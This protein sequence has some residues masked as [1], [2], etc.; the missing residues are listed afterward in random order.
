M[1][2]ADSSQL[3]FRHLY[4]FYLTVKLG[5]LSLAAKELRL[6]VSALSL[7]IRKLE[8][9]IGHVLFTR[10]GRSLRP[11]EMGR[12]LFE[13]AREI[14][15]LGEEVIQLS[16]EHESEVKPSQLT[17]GV[18]DNVPKS[19]CARLV[20]TA[21]TASRSFLSVVELPGA[22]LFRM[23][24]DHQIDLV[25]SDEEPPASESRILRSRSIGRVPVIISGSPD[26]TGLRRNFP[27]SLNGQPF[28]FPSVDDPL[29]SRLES[30]FDRHRIKV[31]AVAQAT[32]LSLLKL[33]AA[34]G[35]G[36]F[37]LPEPA[38]HA[39]KSSGQLISLGR[40]EGIYEEFYICTARRQ[41][42]NPSAEK[43]YRE[44]RL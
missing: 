21:R 1:T 44:F 16:S 40:C 20:R 11:T 29:R 26:R 41:I 12:I 6:G 24:V 3:N 25:L 15:R 27:N 31:E 19:L 2:V 14:F 43:L 18:P 35:L 36:L 9:D 33:L 30:Y 22:K 17:I 13:Y 39:F 5:S 37:A 10:Q 42:P 8:E 7:Q 23:L 34:Q 28:L 32:D 4:Y 38:I